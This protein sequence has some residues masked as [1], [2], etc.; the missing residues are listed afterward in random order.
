VQG[1]ARAEPGSLRGEVRRIGGL[2]V[3]VDCYNANPQS[4]RAALDLLHGQSTASRTVAVLGTMLELGEAAARLHEETLSYVLEL[5]I[6]LVV[7]TGAF[8]AADVVTAHKA[9]ATGGTAATRA[10]DRVLC[11]DDWQSAYPFLRERLD[12]DEVVLLKA[13][14]GVAL[15]GILPSLERDFGAQ[16]QSP[17]VEA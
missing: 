7:A 6:D 9:T 2:T 11:A 8:A 15:E 13:S 1:I 12:G 14:R 5:D 17:A 4:V 16:A 3:V 10:A